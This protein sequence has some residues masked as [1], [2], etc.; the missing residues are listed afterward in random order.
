LWMSSLGGEMVGGGTSAWYVDRLVGGRG[1]IASPRRSSCYFYQFLLLLFI[2]I[3]QHS[4]LLCHY[5]SILAY[6]LVT[7]RRL[8]S[9]RVSNAPPP[10]PPAP[11]L[12]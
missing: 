7:L 1:Q 4:P 6:R 12:C 3:H 2:Y 9:N 11:W 10:P 8:G 5:L